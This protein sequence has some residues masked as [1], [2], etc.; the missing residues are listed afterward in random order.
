MAKDVDITMITLNCTVTTLFSGIDFTY[1]N[2]NYGHAY[3]IVPGISG[4]TQCNCSCYSTLTC[5]CNI[6]Q[7]ISTKTT[8]LQIMDTNMT[9]MFGWYTCAHGSYKTSTLVTRPS[10]CLEQGVNDTTI[11]LSCTP[12]ELKS[13]IDFYFPN[14][15]LGHAYCSA[16]SPELSNDQCNCSCNATSAC[17]CSI[18]QDIATK[19]TTLLIRDN[20]LTSL[21]GLYTCVHGPTNKSTMVAIHNTSTQDYGK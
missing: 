21:V 16:P 6:T 10:L 8:T 4:D 2:K 1:P 15:T 17:K 9:G 18:I 14:I 3:C 13:R 20:N 19:I 12:D 5:K 7:N 11:K